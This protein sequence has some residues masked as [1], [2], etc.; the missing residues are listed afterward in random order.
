MGKIIYLTK[1]YE[2]IVDDIYYDSLNKFCWHPLECNNNLVYAVCNTTIDKV[3]VHYLMHH[4]VMKL[5]GKIIPKGY[6]VDHINRNT[7]DT[8]YDNLRITTRIISSHNRGVFCNSTSGITG[9]NFHE[10]TAKWLARIQINK[11][12]QSKSYDLFEEA[13]IKRVSWE[14]QYAKQI[15]K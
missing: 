2:F 7:F 6:I 10:K 15:G 1:G 4:E 9:V 8:R 12:R 13:I 14:R 11:Y 5:A 3:W